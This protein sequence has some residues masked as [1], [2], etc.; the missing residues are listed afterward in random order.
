MAT[1]S[2]VLKS[3][4]KTPAPST[5]LT[6]DYETFKARIKESEKGDLIEGVMK[7]KTPP[8]SE[9]ERIFMLL[10]FLMNGYATAK[11][12][13][14]VLGSRSLVKIDNKNGYEP[15]IVFVA[16]QRSDIIK[17]YE[18]L[19]AP[20]VVVEIVSK[21][22][23]IDDRVKKFQYYEKSGVKEYWLI[24]P[25]YKSAEL[26]ELYEWTDGYFVQVDTDDNIFRSIALSGFWFKLDWLFS[27]QPL[28]HYQLLQEILRENV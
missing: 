8:S 6:L 24:D 12:L 25:R 27:S 13:G 26:Y 5:E 15:D 9:H 20:D 19:G 3:R 21:S 28:N 14:E 10:A 18:I 22:S 16:E 11:S 23:R 17:E 4:K 1:A 2:A 7:L